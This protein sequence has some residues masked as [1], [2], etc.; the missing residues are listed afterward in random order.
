MFTF[1]QEGV[2]VVLVQE[3]S[4]TIAGYSTDNILTHR[5]WDWVQPTLACCGVTSWEI[6]TST[7][8]LPSSW[9]VSY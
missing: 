6:W 4:R 9:Q 8:V 5:F 7:A 3:L 2:S 1:P